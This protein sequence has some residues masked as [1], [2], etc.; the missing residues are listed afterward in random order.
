MPLILF[1]SH[2]CLAQQRL[3]KVIFAVSSSRALSLL[4]HC[5]ESTPH[6]INLDYIG[7]CMMTLAAMEVNEKS[8]MCPYTHFALVS[9]FSCCVV[10][11]SVAFHKKI[12]YSH[13]QECIVVLAAIGHMPS[14]RIILSS[15]SHTS[16]LLLFSA[17]TFAI[18]YFIIKPHHHTAWHW[19]AAA[20]QLAV[21]KACWADAP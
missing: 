17:I 1:L 4:Y 11:F 10:L 16:H 18:G 15:S 9:C 6:M 21:V 20:A 2:A 8:F 14:L 13:S 5:C 19:T 7:I 12:V 3:T